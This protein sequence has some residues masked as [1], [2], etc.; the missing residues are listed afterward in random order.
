MYVK[1]AITSSG[2]KNSGD[3][4]TGDFDI[5]QYRHP[6]WLYGR[7]LQKIIVGHLRANVRWFSVWDRIKQKKLSKNELD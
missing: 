4:K 1:I 5:D 2:Y 6:W 7:V 3:K